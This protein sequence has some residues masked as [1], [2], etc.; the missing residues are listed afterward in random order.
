MLVCCFSVNSKWGH[1][2]VHGGSVSGADEGAAQRDG[3]DGGARDGEAAAGPSVFVC[4]WRWGDV[5]GVTG[6]CEKA[7]AG[8]KQSSTEAGGKYSKE[9]SRVGKLTQVTKASMKG[10]LTSSP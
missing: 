10:K 7:R 9:T 8:A 2:G 5:C 1:V 3:V 6:G 4:L